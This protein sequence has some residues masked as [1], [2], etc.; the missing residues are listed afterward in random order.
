MKIF[1][2][3]NIPF[4]TE[5][6]SSIGEVS[7]FDGRTVANSDLIDADILLVRSVTKVNESLLKNTRVQFVASATI[8]TDHIDF[9]YLT[10]QDI[11]FANAPASN[12]IS[13][14]EYTLCALLYF[15]Q[16]KDFP[17]SDMQVGIVGYGNVGSRVKQR[18]DTVGIKSIIF[19]PP[20]AEQFKDVDYTD[21]ESIKKCNVI[22]AHVPLTKTGKHPTYQMFNEDFFTALP[23]N[24]LFINTSRGD[25]VDETVLLEIL[26]TKPLHLILDVWQH[27]PTINPELQTQTLIST[28]H[29]AG[30]SFDGKL[31]GTEMIYQAT[32]EHLA[33][34]LQWQA[35][36]VLNDHESNTLEF[37]TSSKHA[38]WDVLQQAYA[39]TEDSQRLSNTMS[40][41][42]AERA[43][44]FDLL[45]KNYPKRR[46][47]SYFEVNMDEATKEQQAILQK[48][49]FKVNSLL[50]A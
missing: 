45:R 36:G 43:M 11:P 33:I 23:D 17:L 22:T 40:L 12:A 34:K 18:L 26:K 28:P 35:S 1:A 20:R 42:E 39:I 49:G 15:S 31:R 13:A 4:A 46:E 14:A 5:A 10:K 50:T 41:P 47:F 24:S 9:E 29:I 3:Q 21:W 19:D 6:F 2:D 44:E 25:A 27:E 7:L 48:L 8:G 32:C 38:L 37:H 30:Y 16:L